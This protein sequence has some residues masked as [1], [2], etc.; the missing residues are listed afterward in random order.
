MRPDRTKTT[1]HNAL[2]RFYKKINPDDIGKD[3][4]WEWC[5]YK[6]PKG[7]GQFKTPNGLDYAHRYSWKIHG[8]GDVPSGKYVMHT[9]DNPRCVNPKHLCVGTPS[10]NSAD[11]VSKKRNKRTIDPK[12]AEIIFAEYV[13]GN[14][15]IISLS[16]KYGHGTATIRRAIGLPKSENGTNK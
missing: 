16:A 13:S 2:E 7:Y 14:T 3:G 8:G 10:D 1:E 11:M 5:G 12:T 6:T 9:C 15:D 4:C